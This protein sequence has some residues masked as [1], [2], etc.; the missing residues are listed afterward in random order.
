MRLPTVA[1]KTQCHCAGLVLTKKFNAPSLQILGPG[2]VDS[3]LLGKIARGGNDEAWARSIE[4]GP[5][6]GLFRMM[7]AFNDNVAAKIQI[8]ANSVFSVLMPLS[9]INKIDARCPINRWIACA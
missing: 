9:D 4:E 3:L 7:L 8:V 6:A 5:G 1:T 2:V